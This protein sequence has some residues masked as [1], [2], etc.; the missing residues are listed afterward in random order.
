MIKTVIVTLLFSSSC[1]ALDVVSKKERVVLNDKDVEKKL[2]V[3]AHGEYFT[4]S[5]SELGSSISGPSFGLGVRYGIN[6][7]VAFGGAIKQN[8]ATIGASASFTSIEINGYWSNKVSMIKR[9]QNFS[10]NNETVL[11]GLKAGNN[12]FLYGLHISQYI[13][14]GTNAA[15]PLTGL[16]GSVNYELNTNKITYSVGARMDYLVNGDT[17]VMPMTLTFGVGFWL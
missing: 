8:F 14:N 4:A 2:K 11:E 17:T 13:F 7:R 9:D 5:N 16:G 1:L 3:T 15:L 12:G 10:V 6:S